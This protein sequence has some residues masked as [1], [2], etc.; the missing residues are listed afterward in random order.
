M[1][2]EDEKTETEILTEEIAAL[3]TKI[4]NTEYDLQHMFK[5]NE[6][7]EQ[8]LHNTKKLMEEKQNRLFELNP[9]QKKKLIEI[10]KQIDEP[11]ETEISIDQEKILNEIIEDEFI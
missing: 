6:I 3:Q 10:E 8:K 4:K 9:D 1:K 5:G 11:K 2:P 7:I